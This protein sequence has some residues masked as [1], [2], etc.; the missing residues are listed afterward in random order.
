VAILSLLH[1]AVANGTNWFVGADD[2]AEI[3]HGEIDGAHR[4]RENA[5]VEQ[6]TTGPEHQWK[7][8][9]AEAV[10]ELVLQQGLEQVSASLDL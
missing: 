2:G 8:H 3:G 4:Y 7:R 6:A 1:V 10:D 5:V 9:Q